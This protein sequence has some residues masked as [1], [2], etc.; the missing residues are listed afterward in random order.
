MNTTRLVAS[1]SLALFAQGALASTI[2]LKD[3]QGNVCYNAGITNANNPSHIIGLGGV[4][5][6]GSGFTLTIDNPAGAGKPTTGD[7]ANIPTTTTPMVFSGGS[8][9]GNIVHVSSMGQGT[10]G[11]NE[12][13]DQGNNLSG[14]RGS[15]TLGSGAATKTLAFDFSATN[16]CLANT[17]QAPF[18]RN[19]VI[20]T[21]SL[22]SAR[23]SQI[24]FQGNYYL[25]NPAA[26]IPEPGS[27]LLLLAGLL[28]MGFLSLRSPRR[29]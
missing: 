6:D 26:T 13:L 15:A 24:V 11:A 10:K 19:V 7:C 20:S 28:G 16:G 8:V 3:R 17:V 5:Q 29:V 9:A 1:I 14:V 27:F 4:N 21:G 23:G 22:A 12:C 25:F 2:W 18:A